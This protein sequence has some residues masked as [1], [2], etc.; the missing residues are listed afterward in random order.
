VKIVYRA[1]FEEARPFEREFAGIQRIEPLSRA[2]ENQITILHV[3]RP[4]VS[5]FVTSKQGINTLQGGGG[6]NGGGSP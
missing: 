1:S 3:G 2:Q 6:G 5:E 4:A